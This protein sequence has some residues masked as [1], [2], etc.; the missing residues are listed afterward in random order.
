[1]PHAVAGLATRAM[2]L[3]C[4]IMSHHHHAGEVHPS[5][6]PSPSLLRLSALS[7]LSMAVALS[8]AI[9]A[10]TVWAMS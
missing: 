6:Q 10:L 8:A 3:Y 9:W 7:L 4:N 5:P 1:M 2:M